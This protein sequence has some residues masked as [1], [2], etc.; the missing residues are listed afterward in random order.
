MLVCFF[1]SIAA[2][3]QTVLKYPTPTGNPNQLFFLQR[4]PNINTIVYELNF[5]NAELV[6]D[7]PVHAY[8]IRYQEKSQREELNY[9]QRNFAYGIK[10]KKLSEDHYELHFVSY[11]SKLMYLK[12]GADNKFNLYTAINKK[13]AILKQI[14]VSVKGGSFWLPNIEYVELKGTDPATGMEVVER[15]KI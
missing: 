12:K 7:E 4:D 5:K 14:F 6:E 3:T 11:K 10:S 15:M 8:W 13:L 9:V 2:H 1:F